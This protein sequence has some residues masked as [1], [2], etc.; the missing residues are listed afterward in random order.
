VKFVS[1]SQT[2]K[3]VFGEFVQPLNPQHPPTFSD[4]KRTRVGSWRDAK[5]LK[6]LAEFF[7]AAAL[8]PDEMDQLCSKGGVS[9]YVGAGALAP[10]DDWRGFEILKK[11]TER[12]PDNLVWF[13]FA[14]RYFRLKREEQL[15]ADEENDLD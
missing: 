11:A 9:E 3:R 10:I 4:F 13:A 14:Y 12:F 15:A 1:F 2:L 5:R 6:E 7:T 8:V